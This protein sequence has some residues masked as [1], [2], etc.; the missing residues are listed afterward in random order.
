MSEK[1]TCKWISNEGDDGICLND[2]SAFCADYCP[3]PDEQKQCRLFENGIFPWISV[4]D[5]LPEIGKMVLCA[6]Y[7]VDFIVPKEGEP[8]PDAIRRS[9]KEAAEHPRVEVGYYYEDGWSGY[10]GFPMICLPLY[11]M[12]IEY[13]EPP[14]YR[15]EYHE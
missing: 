9:R 7:S 4:D 11:W 12:P 6:I 10:E 13:P 1:T 5:K 8:L 14:K 15:G 3:V 2:K